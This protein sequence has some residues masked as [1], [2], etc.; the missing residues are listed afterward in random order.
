MSCKGVCDRYKAKKPVGIGRYTSGQQRC[1]TC[2]IFLNFNGDRC[3][4]CNTLLR[5]SPRQLKYKEKFHTS[6]KETYGERMK[7][8]QKIR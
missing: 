8:D 6:V 4:C 2:E 1:Q 7:N 3:P 5:G